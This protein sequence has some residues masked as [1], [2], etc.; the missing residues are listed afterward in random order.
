MIFILNLFK[1]FS[2]SFNNDFVSPMLALNGFDKDYSSTIFYYFNN[3]NVDKHTYILFI[4]SFSTI[5]N[6]VGIDIYP[7][8]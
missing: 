3:L 5:N 2:V 7:F 1:V 6:I 4:L 8:R